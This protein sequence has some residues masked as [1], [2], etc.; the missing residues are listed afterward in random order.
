MQVQQLKVGSSF[1][2]KATGGTVT[3]TKRG[4]VHRA[5]EAYTGKF[6]EMGIGAPVFD[7]PKRGRGRPKGAKNKQAY[8]TKGN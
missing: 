4:L 6:A 3:I 2:S 7:A 1:V 5:T 8:G